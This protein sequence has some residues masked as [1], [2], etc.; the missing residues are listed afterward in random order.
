MST[1]VAEAHTPVAGSDPRRTQRPRWR[2]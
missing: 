2:L 1:A